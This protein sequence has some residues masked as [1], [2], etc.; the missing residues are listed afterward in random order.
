M[1]T[2]IWSTLLYGVESWTLSE[3]LLKRLEAVEMWLWRRMM[4][5]PWTSRLTN[6]AVLNMVGENRQLIRIARKRQLGFLGHIMRREGM[7]N[8]ALT[9]MIE[10]KRGRGR[11]REKYLDGLVRMTNGKVK[12]PLNI[13][14][15]TKD[16]QKWKSM[17]DNMLKTVVVQ[18]KM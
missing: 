17:T 9:G 15:A 12:T 7:E 14:R 11:P 5:V 8:L 10:G 1:R 6:E 3:R 4:R 18:N 2:Y 13:I 16:R